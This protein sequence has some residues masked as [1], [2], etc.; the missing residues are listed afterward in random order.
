MYTISVSQLLERSTAVND[1]SSDGFSHQH[2]FPLL[3]GPLFSD[4]RQS[5]GLWWPY[6]RPLV[7]H[8]L[9]T[10]LRHFVDN[11]QS[12]D[13]GFP[14]S[15]LFVFKTCTK[16]SHKEPR[17]IHNQIQFRIYLLYTIS[18]SSFTPHLQILQIN[19]VLLLFS[20][21]TDIYNIIYNQQTSTL[22]NLGSAS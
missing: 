10:F 8:F 4:C 22:C 19:S 1:Q 21:P 6:R 2:F 9:P 18:R 20:K 17:A 7:K 3:C 5:F 13:F 11:F 16:V 12:E 15:V 14:H